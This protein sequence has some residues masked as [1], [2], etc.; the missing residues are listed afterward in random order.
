MPIRLKVFHDSQFLLRQDVGDNL[1]ETQPL[2]N[3]VC[4]FL[5]VSG[6]HDDR[7]VVLVQPADRIG[8]RC[9]DWIGDAD[10]SRDILIDHY[11]HHSF[12]LRPPFI[13]LLCQRAWVNVQVFQHCRIAD[14]GCVTVHAA[15]HALPGNGFEVLHIHQLDALLLGIRNDCGRQGM[16]TTAFETGNNFQQS[17]L[18]PTLGA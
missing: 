10:K 8:R 9:L 14:G 1:L 12:A 18:V 5:I 4:R 3:G 13:R 11:E 2:C 15:G 16:L 17:R 7:Y 6:Q